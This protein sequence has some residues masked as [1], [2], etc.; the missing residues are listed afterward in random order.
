MF[1][2]PKSWVQGSTVEFLPESSPVTTETP[3][4]AE[5]KSEPSLGISTNG[6]YIDLFS[7]PFSLL[8]ALSQLRA[9][10]CFV[11]MSGAWLMKC[12]GAKGQVS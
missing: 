8:Q 7:L 12:F 10:L 1:C 5:V 6:F 3:F 9:L 4:A 2:K 11:S